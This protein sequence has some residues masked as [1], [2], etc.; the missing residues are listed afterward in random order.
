MKYFYSISYLKEVNNMFTVN[1]R[2]R[3]DYAQEL[4]LGKRIKWNK[5]GKKNY[6]F[7]FK[8][9]DLDYS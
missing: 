4:E 9:S 1:G 6:K 7:F 8:D 5:W 3:W 2:T